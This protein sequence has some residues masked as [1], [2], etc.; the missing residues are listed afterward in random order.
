MDLHIQFA[1]RSDQRLTVEMILSW[2]EPSGVPGTS[3]QNFVVNRYVWKFNLFQRHNISSG[4]SDRLG[5]VEGDDTDW[6]LAT[7]RIPAS[8]FTRFCFNVKMEDDVTPEKGVFCQ[9]SPLDD[10]DG[11]VG[12]PERFLSKFF[13]VRP[14]DA[15]AKPTKLMSLLRAK[16]Q[17]ALYLYRGAPIISPLARRVDHLLRHISTDKDTVEGFL[18]YG[19]EFI[20]LPESYAEPTP[21]ARSVVSELYGWS[22][23][24][25]LHAELLIESWNGGPL[26]IPRAYFSES[27]RKAHDVYLRPVDD[28]TCGAS[29]NPA[30]FE[31]LMLDLAPYA[32]DN[33]SLHNLRLTRA[34]L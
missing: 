17:S 8:D 22:T 6:Y 19:V 27:L 32:D 14:A 34:G 13:V 26:N 30:S 12:N 31:Q 29:M 21:E 2:L 11:I 24:M 3:F 23:E 5:L 33:Q 28:H 10:S 18:P 1:C 25:Q 16:A 20:G 9:L 15:G 4:D 7:L